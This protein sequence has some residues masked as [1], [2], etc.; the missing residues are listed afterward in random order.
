MVSSNVPHVGARLQSQT[1]WLPSWGITCGLLQPAGG[2]EQLHGSHQ[3]CIATPHLLLLQ[4]QLAEL[5]MQHLSWAESRWEKLT[6]QQYMMHD[7]LLCKGLDANQFHR[8]LWQG[9]RRADI[10]VL[11]VHCCVVWH[12]Y[13]EVHEVAGCLGQGEAR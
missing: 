10:S 7:L 1:G 2:N 4:M 12:S 8:L 13:I 11:L 6:E 3:H 9:Q 5:V